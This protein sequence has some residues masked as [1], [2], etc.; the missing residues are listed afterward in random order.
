MNRP[1]IL[2][3]LRT[4]LSE[5][6]NKEIVDLRPDVRL[7]ED[8]DLD[9][10]SVIDLLMSLEDTIDL[11]IDPDDLGPEVFTTVGSL[12]DYI[13]AQFAKTAA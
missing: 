6:L 1:D 9:S 8:L 11:E 3:A 7:F 4:A 10:T 5:V 13:E 12:C 2:R